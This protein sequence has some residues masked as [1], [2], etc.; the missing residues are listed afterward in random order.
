[1]IKKPFNHCARA[2][3]ALALSVISLLT[4]T[5]RLQAQLAIPWF[6]MD[7]G[8]MN[9]PGGA[10]VLKGS[11]GQ[12]DAGSSAAPMTGGQFT[13]TGGFWTA[14]PGPTNCVCPGD[15]NGD[16]ALDGQDVQGFVECLIAGD[17]CPCADI[18]SVG[19]VTPTDIQLFVTALVAGQGCP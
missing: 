18:N 6:T 11:I 16:G 17:H 12:A 5:T 3:A 9:S 15:M 14:D 4:A 10:Y 8:G 13:L 1:M 19:G 2:T 7:A